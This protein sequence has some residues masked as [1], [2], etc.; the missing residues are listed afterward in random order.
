MIAYAAV[1]IIGLVLGHFGGD[2]FIGKV[3]GWYQRF[4]GT[5]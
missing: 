5:K 2:W 4:G 3:R 1:L